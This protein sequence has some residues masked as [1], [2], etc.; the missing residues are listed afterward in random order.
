MTAPLP[1]L[2]EALRDR[3][4][5]ERELGRG[6]MAVVYLARDI[7][8]D[9]PVAVKV[10]HPELAAALGPERFLNEIRLTARL[11]HPHILPLFDSGETAGLL[12]YVM[13]Y[14]DGESLRQRLQRDK[15]LSVEDAL[16][17][18]GN[19]LAALA[20]AHEHGIIHRDIKPDNILIERGEAVVADFGIAHA[21]NAAG[22]ERLTETGVM[23]GT[24]AYMSPEQG[25]AARDLDARSD[26]YSFGCV[27]YEMLAGEPPFRGPTAQAVIAQRFTAPVPKL[28]WQRDT[29]PELVEQAVERSLARLPADRFAT[30]AQF[31]SALTLPQPAVSVA[32]AP[33]TARHRLLAWLGLA[34]ALGLGA[35]ILLSRERAAP[36]DPAADVIAVAPFRVSGADPALGYLREGMV[37]LLAAKLTGEAGPRAVDPRTALAAWRRSGALSDRDLPQEAMVGIAR[38]LGAGQLL[39]G[40]VVGTSTRLVLNVAVV[41]ASKSGNAARAS[42]NGSAD[43]LPALIDRLTAQLLAS[44]AGESQ[45]RLS[46]VT[47][48]SLEALRAYLDGRAAY[49]RGEY[50]QGVEQFQRALADDSAFALAGMGLAASA[51]WLRDAEAGRRGLGVA[52]AHRTRLSARD[53]AILTGYVGPRYPIP[54]ARREL[55]AAWERAVKLAPDQPEVWY[56]LG[57]LLYHFG[58]VLGEPGAASRATQAFKRAV[59]LDSTY[60][61][62]LSHLVDIAA[63]TGDTTALRR[64]GALWLAADSMSEVADFTRWRIAATVGEAAALAAVRARFDSMEFQS[65]RR[66]LAAMQLDPVMLG[67]ADRVAAALLRAAASSDD[68]ARA[69]GM[70]RELA[71]NRGRPAQALVAGR[72]W[73]AA[74]PASRAS[75]RGL[76]SD[77]LYGD[78]DRAAAQRA[79][80][81]L[82]QSA[83]RPPAPAPADRVEQ[84]WDACLV[85]LW[86]VVQG[87]IRTAP[88]AIALLRSVAALE[89]PESRSAALCA[90]TLQ[91]MTAAADRGRGGAAL[92]Q[93]D[94]LLLTGL[95]SQ[96]GTMLGAWDPSFA[97]S[98]GVPGS[99]VLARLL[100]TQ[101]DPRAALAA[102]R[103]RPYVSTL[104]LYLS[105]FLREEGRL[106]ALTGDSAGAIRAYKHYL[107]LRSDPEPSIKPEVER[108]RAE[109]AALEHEPAT[110]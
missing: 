27:L 53:R 42:V 81:E 76:I 90:S 9:R 110:Q 13:P 51:E 15:Q 22:G 92:G 80:A 1:Q 34:A 46:A 43:S 109:L 71:L 23:L 102:V 52:W 11:Q 104:V 47:S 7:K 89:G 54:A 39:L 60:A 14:V 25:S 37:D 57:D 68:R 87:E 62:P 69:I 40:E 94:S 88:Q 103:R 28:R 19:V 77:A 100:E 29:V 24:P 72:S 75:V 58:G 82:S 49:R 79:V 56:E 108:V 95:V 70:M 50:R 16:Q 31:A 63:R 3:Y 20:Y 59:A 65:L 64:L 67:D 91:A 21:V 38:R 96:D 8:H 6:G 35:A 30:A 107:A 83:D 99:L 106:A 86:R 10:L 26:L 2:A 18:A 32:R 84:G 97:G 36:A 45:Q 4:A 73:R 55:L 66:I 74:D 17:I 101:G 48:T 85:N 41:N 33:A 105:T 61:A 44:R 98:L 5:L 78:G 12:Y 93:L